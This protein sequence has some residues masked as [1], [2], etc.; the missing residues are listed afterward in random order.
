L[1][2]VHGA[3][4]PAYPSEPNYLWLEA[5]TNFGIFDN[6]D[7]AINH[8]NTTNHLAAQL[9]AADISW[10]SYQEDIDGLSVPL[11]A[12]N[13]YVPR[14][15]PFVYF[16]DITGTNDANDAY[17]IAHNRPYSELATDLTNNTVAR[18]NFI[19]PNMCNCG[20]DSCPPQ[21]V[22]VTVENFLQIFCNPNLILLLN[23]VTTRCARRF[24]NQKHVCARN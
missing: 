5:G 7:P 12:T 4:R 22:P 18:Y 13:L 3:T 9:R 6:N 19:T 20:H 14:H 15:N 24:A 23:P 2:R 11:V 10:R 21:A 16:D 17:G 8:Q 1:R